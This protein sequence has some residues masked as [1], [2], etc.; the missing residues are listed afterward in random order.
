MEGEKNFPRKWLANTASE[1]HKRKNICTNE[2]NR[3]PTGVEQGKGKAEPG[4]GAGQRREVGRRGEQGGLAIPRPSCR[5][6]TVCGG[7]QP[8]ATPVRLRRGLGCREEAGRGSAGE[9]AGHPS[10]G[11]V[12]AQRWAEVKACRTMR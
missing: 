1:D 12:E 10:L 6:R 2:H 9:D 4:F 11:P 3:L 7:Q 8:L 5:G